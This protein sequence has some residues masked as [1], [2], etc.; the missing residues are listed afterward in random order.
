MC[1]DRH[2]P[3][4]E[5]W[6]YDR[7]MSGFHPL[8]TRGDQSSSASDSSRAPSTSTPCVGQPRRSARGTWKWLGKHISIPTARRQCC[9]KPRY[10]DARLP[11]IPSQA[12]A[13]RQFRAQGR[14]TTQVR[15]FTGAR[16]G[17]QWNRVWSTAD[18]V[19][20]KLASTAVEIS[21]H[22]I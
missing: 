18:R 9:R 11:R 2:Y 22:I 14:P 19:F 8:R 5:Y 16:K 17:K 4:E 13:S 15:A 3:S 7:L 1:L 10:S 21:P 20:T 6:Q 12:G